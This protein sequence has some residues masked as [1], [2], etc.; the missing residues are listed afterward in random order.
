MA[1]TLLL[2]FSLPSIKDC[3]E[4]NTGCFKFKIPLER[5]KLY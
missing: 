1:K 4:D 3:T 2:T 5:E